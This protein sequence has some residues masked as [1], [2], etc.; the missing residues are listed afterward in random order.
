M[1]D[2]LLSVDNEVHELKIGDSFDP[3]NRVAFHS[4]RCE[5]TLYFFMIQV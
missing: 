5:F 2:K 1:T 3:K 4:I